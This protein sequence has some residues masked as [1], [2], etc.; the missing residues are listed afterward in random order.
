V[1]PWALLFSKLRRSDDARV[2]YDE[3]LAAGAEPVLMVRERIL[4][5]GKDEGYEPAGCEHGCTP[6]LDY[7]TRKRERLV[8][9]A[10]PNDPACWPGWTWVARTEVEGLRCRAKDV[11]AALA[12]RNGLEPL[13]VA[14]PPPFVGVGLLRRRGLS[15]PV[16][17]LRSATRGFEQ[18]CRGLRAQL[19]HDAL[20][21]LVA[22]NPRVPFAAS[23]KIAPLELLDDARGDLGLVRALEELTPDY[24]ARVVADQTLDL[25]YV[26]LRFATR[27]GERH[28]LEINGH[29]FGGFRKSDV[30]FLRLLLLAAARKNGKDDGWLDKSRLRDG[31]DKDRALERMREELVTYD[32]PGLPEA[33]RKALVRAQKGQ[34]RLGVPPENIELDASLAGLEF[35]GPTTTVKKSGAKAKATPKQEEGLQNAAVLLR[36]CRRL[37]APGDAEAVKTP[38]TRGR[39]TRSA[40]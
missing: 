25:D 7:D 2:S 36:D 38:S 22:K 16:V 31:D 24:R 23:E 39:S 20:I 26:K 13:A 19:G 21:V 14:V 34:L 6:N 1:K 8:G 32:V 33:E 11:F 18:L 15:V 28:V 3:V 35:I 27:P 29:D 40:T 37:G 4:E 12:A 5:Y 30:K 9:V 10:C 17:W